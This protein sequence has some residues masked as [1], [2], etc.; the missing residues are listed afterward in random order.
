LRNLRLKDKE[1]RQ[2]K[3]IVKLSMMLKIVTL[4][5]DSSSNMSAAILLR[6]VCVLS[7]KIIY[8]AKNLYIK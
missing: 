2:I 1:G 5:L 7:F 8:T 6:V 3:Y 4:L